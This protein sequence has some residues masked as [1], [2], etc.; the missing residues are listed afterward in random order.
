MLRSSVAFAR[1][2]LTF[3]LSLVA[4]AMGVGACAAPAIEDDLG[5]ASRLPDRASSDAGE[6]GAPLTSSD[7]STST[8]DS[9]VTADAAVSQAQLCSEPDLML[10]FGFEGTVVDGSPAMLKPAVS[11]LAFGPGKLGQ[12]AMF[13]SASAM[14]FDAAPS[15]EVTTASVEAWIKRAP[16]PPGDGVIFDDDNRFS[17]TVLADGSVL[18][19][20]VAVI[21]TGKVVVDQWTHVACTFDG[22]QGH[23]YLD[24]VE[25]AAGIGVIGSSPA[26]GAAVGGNAPSG[27]PFVG[28]IDS[29]RA[30]RVA[31]TA[32]QIASAAGK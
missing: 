3:A 14:L 6:D 1:V 31:R 4:G 19:K 24:G 28:A 5:G 25:Q 17:L 11:G 30:F 29:F 15:L 26:S 20:P 13:G 12:A 2:A 23:V 9:A 10:C 22:A 16:N 21:S 32:A 7:A 8:V 18:C 27:E